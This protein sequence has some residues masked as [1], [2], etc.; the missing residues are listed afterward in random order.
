MGEGLPP[1]SLLLVH[2]IHYRNKHLVN[3]LRTSP[4]KVNYKSILLL[5]ISNSCIFIASIF[6]TLQLHVHI[7][8]VTLC[9]LY[10]VMGSAKRAE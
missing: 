1:D 8:K 3:N 5:F 2:Y 4:N 9:D 10:K 7:M 6:V